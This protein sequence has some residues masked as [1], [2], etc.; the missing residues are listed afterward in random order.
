[1][2][3]LGLAE[4]GDSTSSGYRDVELVDGGTTKMQDKRDYNNL[5][6]F[7]PSFFPP[8]LGLRYQR[9]ITNKFSAFVGG[10]RATLIGS[11]DDPI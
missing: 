10:G 1:M 11:G 9:V 6:I 3:G 2:S 5:L 8:G 7:R 4:E